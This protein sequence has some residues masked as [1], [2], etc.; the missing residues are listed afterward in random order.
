MCRTWTAVELLLD[1]G[2]R[3]GVTD[4]SGC[5]PLLAAVKRNMCLKK[6]SKCF[7][8]DVDQTPNEFWEEVLNRKLDPWTADEEGNSVLSI[9]VKKEAECLAKALIEVACELNCVQSDAIGVPLLITICKDK[10]TDKEWKTNFVEILLKSRIG[11]VSKTPSDSNDTPLHFSCRNI[12]KLAKLPDSSVET[13]V[14]WKIVQYLLLCGADINA[15][16]EAGESCLALS[17]NCPVLKDLLSAP[18]DH[19][20]LPLVLENWTPSSQSHAQKLNLVGRLVKCRQV[21]S[22]YLYSEALDEDKGT[23]GFVFA[24]IVQDGREV[25]VKRFDKSRI[26]P[27]KTP[28]SILVLSKKQCEQIVQYYFCLDEGNFHYIAFELM[29]ENLEHY[30]D[31]ASSAGNSTKLCKDLLIGLKCLHSQGIVHGNINP[32][33]VFYQANPSLCLKIGNCKTSS[34]RIGWVATEVLKDETSFSKQSD[35]FSCGLVLHYLLSGKKHPFAPADPVMRTPQE[36]LS[37]THKN[38]TN[39]NIV[40]IDDSLSP[41]ATHLVHLML[42]SDPSHRPSAG[43]ALV[44]PF[45]WEKKTKKAFLNVVG[46]EPEFEVGNRYPLTLFEYELQELFSVIVSSTKW[47]D[48]LKYGQI[49]ATRRRRNYNFGSIADLIRFIRNTYQHIHEQEASIQDWWNK[50][51]IFDYFPRLIIEIYKKVKVYN[52]HKSRPQ[53]QSF[54]IEL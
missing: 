27:E 44:H 6:D 36:I 48:P 28:E 50:Y 23:D 45:F 25:A 30:F 49:S 18:V 51:Y 20:E 43:E 3:P 31:M 52:L 39:G 26:A 29:E 2:A 15:S 35:I 42:D 32:R 41:E 47:N 1:A 10:S 11:L 8:P 22:I 16:G 33:T 4:S 34:S 46:N 53:I 40:K 7:Y 21:R 12:L 17:E 14:H 54:F 19:S 38:I 37:K 24:G 9:L 5:T 13:S